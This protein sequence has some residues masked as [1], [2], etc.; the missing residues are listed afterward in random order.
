M[1]DHRD[2]DARRGRGSG[3]PRARLPRTHAERSRYFGLTFREWNDPIVT[4]SGA[5]SRPV[6]SWLKNLLN[7]PDLVRARQ[8]PLVERS[9]GD[10]AQLSGR[11]RWPNQ[12]GQLEL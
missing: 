12:A 1:A 8:P 9:T 3:R 11:A 2:R 10:K 4:P 5:V 7:R 6:L